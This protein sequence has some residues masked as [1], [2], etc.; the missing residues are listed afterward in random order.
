MEKAEKIISKITGFLDLLGG[1]AVL[2]VM[3]LAVTNILLRLLVNGAI[4][5]TY[6]FVGFITALVLGL[7]LAHCAYG[8]GHIAI[9]IVME[10][11]PAKVQLVVGILVYLASAG[12][13]ILA[14]YH[15]YLY[16]YSMVV[17]GQ[18]S[19]TTQ[20]PY[21]PF[22]YATAVGFLFL[23]VIYLFKAIQLLSKGKTK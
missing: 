15:M 6:E 10:K 16:G 21:Y 14:S 7:A 22:I 17:S 3:L 8:N 4:L 19:P 13:F 11:F 2:A 20:T 23:F 5:G 1:M 18:V 12:F 9:E